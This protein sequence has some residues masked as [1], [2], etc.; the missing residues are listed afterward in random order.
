MKLDPNKHLQQ[1]PLLQK[2]QKNCRKVRLLA[3]ITFL[4]NSA[5]NWKAKRAFPGMRTETFFS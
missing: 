4:N 2:F 1:Y 3:Q 5:L